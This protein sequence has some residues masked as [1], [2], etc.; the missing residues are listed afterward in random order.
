MN[1]GYEMNRIAVYVIVFINIIL[2][3][4]NSTL[5]CYCTPDAMSKTYQVFEK[6]WWGTKR[7][8]TCRY[9]CYDNKGSKPETV[10]GSGKENTWG[11]DIGTEGVCEGLIY[12]SRLNPYTLWEDYTL[13][14]EERIYRKSAKA[15]ELKQWF[16]TNCN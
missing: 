1:W 9:A 6:K 13:V 10:V 16:K 7:Q 3:L 12:E 14:G 11:A 5:A 8:W 15:P 4:S 2:G